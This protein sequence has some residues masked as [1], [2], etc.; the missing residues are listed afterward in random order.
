MSADDLAASLSVR[1]RDA[2]RRVALLDVPGDEKTCV[3]ARLIELTDASKRDLGRASHR[4]D[5]LLAELDAG[6]TGTADQQDE[7][8]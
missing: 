4:L 5:L 3:A 1:L 8:P 7:H 6:R 2:H